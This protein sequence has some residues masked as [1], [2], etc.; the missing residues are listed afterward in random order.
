MNNGSNNT[1]I[2]G[3]KTGELEVSGKRASDISFCNLFKRWVLLRERKD[4]KANENKKTTV[5]QNS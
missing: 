3:L 4:E 1:V 5:L 2:K